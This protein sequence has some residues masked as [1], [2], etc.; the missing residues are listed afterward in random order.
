MKRRNVTK[1]MSMSISRHYG[2]CNEDYRR[3][4]G[5]WMET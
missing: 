2:A 3:S 4:M 1:K 5:L